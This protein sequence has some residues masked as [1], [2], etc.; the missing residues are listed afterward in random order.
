VKAAGKV[1]I[2]VTAEIIVLSSYETSSS[3]V[4]QDV[5]DN[6]SSSLNASALNTTI[7][8]DD[9]S[10]NAHNVAGLDKITITHFNKTGV[11]GTV[12]SIAAGRNEY[13][14]AGTVTVTVKTR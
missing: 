1:L 6:I 5:A 12:T 13:L 11:S 14:A 8:V 3:T 4:K 9:V 2:D 10:A 7:D